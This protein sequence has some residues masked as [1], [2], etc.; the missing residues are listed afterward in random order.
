M[1]GDLF[2]PL[3]VDYQS[4]PKIIEAGHVAEVLFVRS[5]AMSKRLLSDGV[6][7]RV[8]LQS[9]CLGLPGRPVNIA[10]TLV[11]VGLWL[12]TDD[13]WQIANW[14]KWNPSAAS[15]QAKAARKRASALQANHERWHV[16]PSGK[17]ND[18]CPICYPDVSE[19]DPNR[20]PTPITVGIHKGREGKG[21]Q[22]EGKPEGRESNSSS[23]RNSQSQEPPADDP[24]EDSH[25]T[26]ID[27]FISTVV[28]HIATRRTQSRRPANPFAYKAQ[29]VA[30]LNAHHRDAIKAEHERHPRL[31]ASQLADH[32]EARPEL[33]PGAAS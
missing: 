15:L 8:Q 11:K 32:Y 3:H 7:K 21:S 6:V 9:L 29:V 18:S 26:G 10:A 4:D 25:D 23:S 19:S 12:E 22:R 13:G 2:T 27:E 33:H 14:L 1:A 24:P 30:D 28:S 20:T 5:L 17:P 31:D 16:P